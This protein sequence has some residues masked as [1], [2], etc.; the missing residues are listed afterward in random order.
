M[1]NIKRT[2]SVDGYLSFYK[3]LRNKIAQ[4]AEKLLG[5]YGRIAVEILLTGPDLFI[6]LF[7][8]Y[9]DPEIPIEYKVG[10]ASVLTYWILPLDIFSELFTGVLGYIDDIFL[11]AYILHGLMKHLD[12]AKIKSYW[13]GCEK[14]PDVIEKILSYSQFFAALLGK[15][16]EQKFNQLVSR[17]EKRLN[18]KA[19]KTTAEE[20]QDNQPTATFE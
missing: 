8:I 17:I 11:S 18:L 19:P 16:S 10:L 20:S 15:N 1:E 4:D 7:R 5:K 14:A 3:Y 6:F 2:R 12:E 9:R 13:P